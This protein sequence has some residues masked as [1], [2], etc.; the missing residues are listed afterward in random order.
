MPTFTASVNAS[1]DDAQE[2][3]GT[4]NLTAT[5]LN[6][7]FTTHI[8]GM[9]FL[10]VTIPQGA[11]ITAATLDIYLT[12]TSYDDPDVNIRG[13]DADNPGTFTSTTNN[14]SNRAMTTA[15]VN[16]IAS[17]LGTGTKTSPDISSIV[18]E[19]VDRS[20][21]ASGNAMVIFINGNNSASLLRWSSADGANPTPTLT[22][23]Y[24]TST[25]ITLKADHYRKL[26]TQP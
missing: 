12:S 3:S 11:T 15:T 10:N 4:M 13:E 8:S 9:R 23:T 6:A 7:N 18:Q 14:I 5:T 26:L 22:V 1:S 2:S 19:I 21:W 25:G 17:T 24:S 16:W 20:G